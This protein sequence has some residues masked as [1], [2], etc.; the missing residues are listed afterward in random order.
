MVPAEVCS[1]MSAAQDHRPR[2]AT[3]DGAVLV[4]DPPVRRLRPARL[5]AYYRSRRREVPVARVLVSP[6]PRSAEPGPVRQLEPRS[7]LQR[8]V[9]YDRRLGAW[10]CYVVALLSLLYVPVLVAG[11]VAAAPGAP[12]PDPYNAVLE[13]LIVPSSLA[14]VIAFVAVH[15]RAAPQ[16]R[17]LS[18]GAVALVALTAGVTICVHAVL[19]TVERQADAS[20]LPGYDLLL[21][22]LWPSVV[23]RRGH[24][25]LGPLP[26]GDAPPGRR[27]PARLALQAPGCQRCPLSRRHHGAVTC[28]LNVRDIGIVGYASCSR[29]PCCCRADGSRRPSHRR[30]HPERP[31]R[32]VGAPYGGS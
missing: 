6:R 31:C 16:R 2:L 14:M 9:E 5:A 8:P 24:R 4:G 12:V 13:L 15:R 23:L 25:G 3:L 32:A 7:R 1:P 19:L 27:R 21:S 20:R 29:S 18:A 10:S 11:L 30:P 22:W 26:R 17:L 28:D